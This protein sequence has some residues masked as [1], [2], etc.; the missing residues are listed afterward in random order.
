MNG[1][2]AGG[3]GSGGFCGRPTRAVA[4]VATQRP[5]LWA[6]AGT[7]NTPVRVASAA[8]AMMA[9]VTRGRT[10]RRRMLH[11]QRIVMGT[12]PNFRILLQFLRTLRAMVRRDDESARALSSR[13][14]SPAGASPASVSA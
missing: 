9:T 10:V 2:G 4:Q 13:R 1:G 7:E 12:V 14:S 8:A 5:L 11:P 3:P 6:L